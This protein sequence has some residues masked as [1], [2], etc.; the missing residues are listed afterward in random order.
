MYLENE[1]TE[2]ESIVDGYHTLFNYLDDDKIHLGI[3]STEE[4]R[5]ELFKL[6]TD[7]DY[8]CNYLKCNGMID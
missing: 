5:K 2:Q 4:K 8:L 7:R 3:M 6:R 1:Y